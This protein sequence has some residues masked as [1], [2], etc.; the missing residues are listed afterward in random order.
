MC[1]CHLY[2]DQPA[3][4]HAAVYRQIAT[5]LARCFRHHDRLRDLGD[6]LYCDAGILAGYAERLQR[7]VDVTLAGCGNCSDR[8][9]LCGCGRA[10]FARKRFDR[11]RH[12]R[13]RHRGD[14]LHRDG[15]VRSPGAHSLG[16][17]A[18]V[19]VDCARCAVRRHRTARWT[20]PRRDSME[21]F[22]RVAADARNLQPS[23]HGDGRGLAPSGSDNSIV[24]NGGAVRL[25]GDCG[26]ARNLHHRCPGARRRRN[27]G[28]IA[29][30]AN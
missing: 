19:G 1:A 4:S 10:Q 9:R 3:A 15:R 24:G 17:G 16:S 29:G 27:R 6:S 11:R 13:R 5:H 8:C 26:G 25:A 30:A 14:A 22:R 21:D 28:A 2:S 18:G 20:A 12:R 7:G 23:F